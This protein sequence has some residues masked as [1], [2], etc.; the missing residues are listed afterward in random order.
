MTKPTVSIVLRGL[1][2]LPRV[3]PGDDLAALIA[4]GLDASGL[5]LEAGDVLVVAQKIVSKAEGRYADLATVSPSTAAK[6]LAEET[7][8]DPRLVQIVLDQSRRVLRHRPGV[9][10]VEHNLGFVMANAGI[11]QSNI[12]G[13][14]QRVLLLPEDPDAS[15]ARLRE[16][17]M[18][19]LGVAPAIVISDSFGRPWRLGTVGVAIG[20]AGLP[21]LVDMRGEPDMNGRPLQHTEIG[22]A[23]EIASA[24]SLVM[25]Q[26]AEQVPVVLVRGLPPRAGGGGAAS[27][28]RPAH[29]DMFR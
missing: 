22:L 9:I 28:I 1:S 23:D 13:G 18:Q 17:L 5:S 4:G 26:A 2:G 16:M 11:D 3:Q 6:N 25:G 15:S 10:V 7:G 27:L 24:A 19:R 20:A 14:D 8:K 21:A 12:E 29:E